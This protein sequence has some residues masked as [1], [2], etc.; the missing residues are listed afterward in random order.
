MMAASLWSLMVLTILAP[1]AAEGA[2]T[3]AGLPWTFVAL[4]IAGAVGVVAGL[5]GYWL[6]SGKTGNR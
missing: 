4:A 1:A 6:W 3:G 2:E 5:G